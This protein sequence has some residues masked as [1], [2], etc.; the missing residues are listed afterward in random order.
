MYQNQ[1]ALSQA[2]Q[3]DPRQPQ[4]N[5]RAQQQDDQAILLRLSYQQRGGTVAKLMGGS[6]GTTTATGSIRGSVFLDE[7]QDGIRSASGQAANQVIVLL[8]DRYAVQTN[9]R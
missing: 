7:N 9:E 8:H 4:Q 1:L 5:I 6:S 2:L 3:L